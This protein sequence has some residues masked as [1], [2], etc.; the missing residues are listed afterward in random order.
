MTN[1]R[2]PHSYALSRNV[3]FSGQRESGLTSKSIVRL[4]PGPKRRGSIEISG[5][6]LRCLRFLLFKA[7][8][9]RS[10]QS[11]SRKSR[12][13]QV[14]VVT[15]EEVLDEFL[16]YYG[17]HGPILRNNAAQAVDDVRGIG[18]TIRNA[19]R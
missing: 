3:P 19:P 14:T 4:S 13:G 1:K 9:Q 5:P 8:L 12:F 16:T 6:A 18:D 11:P 17:S 10:R 7:G 2:W 15:T